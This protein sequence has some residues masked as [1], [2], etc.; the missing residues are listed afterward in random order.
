MICDYLVIHT[1]YTMRADCQSDT[2][3]FV[4]IT[5]GITSTEDLRDMVD[6][7]ACSVFRASSLYNFTRK[8][9][10]APGLVD[11]NARASIECTL[12]VGMPLRYAHQ[13]A[14]VHGFCD[15]QSLLSIVPMARSTASCH[16]HRTPPVFLAFLVKFAII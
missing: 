11:F 13:R 4:W 9:K 14:N 8:L 12:S 1:L 3:A 5:S 2:I 10:C 15:F 7:L 16:S 6:Y